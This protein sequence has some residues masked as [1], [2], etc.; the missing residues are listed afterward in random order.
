MNTEPAAP[1]SAEAV[2]D[3]GTSWPEP[4]QDGYTVDD[5]Y[6][7]PELPR[8]TQLIDGSLVFAARQ[9]LFH[10]RMVDL[11]TAG[12]RGTLVPPLKVRRQMSVELD[13]RNMPEP[14]VSVVR[15]D[16]AETGPDRTRYLASEV[17]LAVEVV[18]PDSEARDRDTKPRKYAAAGIPHFWLVERAGS[19]GHPVVRVHE[20]D[21]VTKSYAITGIHHDELKSSVPYDIAVDISL[22][23]LREL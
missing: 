18:S 5:V 10:M 7:L 6:T 9:Q 17:L 12:L 1:P 3:C 20:L 14:D 23:A 19:D 21:P 22:E 15:E 16:A 11:L 13:R 8:H 2:C 4:P